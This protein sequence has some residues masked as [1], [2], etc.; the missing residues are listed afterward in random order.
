[1]H[2]PEFVL[3]NETHKPLWDF[4]IQTD[5]LISARRQDLVIV[6]NNHNKQKRKPAEKWTLSSGETT[7]WKY[8]KTKRE[9]NYWILLEN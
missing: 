2:N 3:E 6:N 1:M 4:E 9:I 7:E 5:H 8:K